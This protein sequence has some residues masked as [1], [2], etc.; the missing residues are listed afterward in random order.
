MFA[1]STA[2][3]PQAIGPYSQACRHGDL[4]FVSGQLPIDPVTGSFASDRAAEQARQCIVNIDAIVK[5]GGATL[6][7]TVKTTIYLTDLADFAA[8]NDV[9]GQLFMEPYPA[10]ACVQVAALPRGAKVEIDAVVAI[11]PERGDA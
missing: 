2:D 11:V 1:L 8:V 6:S 10:R 9:Y 3:A 7:S 5:A 4:I